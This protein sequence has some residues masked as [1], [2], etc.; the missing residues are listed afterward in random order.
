[1]AFLTCTHFKLRSIKNLSDIV[2]QTSERFLFRWQHSHA[3]TYGL[4]CCVPASEMTQQSLT[5]VAGT[6]QQQ[7]RLD[8][9][10]SWMM[11]QYSKSKGKIKGKWQGRRERRE[12]VNR[13]ER[14]QR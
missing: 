2:E 3:Q 12:D 8:K 14:L 1:M 11:T 7:N 6:P 9:E 13:G 10:C 4:S 5:A